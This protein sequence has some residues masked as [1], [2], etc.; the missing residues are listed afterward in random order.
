MNLLRV[1][2]NAGYMVVERNES[3][4]QVN[5]V[6]LIKGMDISYILAC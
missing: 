4:R 1:N 3:S 5:V 6:C 2:K